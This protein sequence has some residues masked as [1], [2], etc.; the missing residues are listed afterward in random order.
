[1]SKYE[2]NLKELNAESF[3]INCYKGQIYTFPDKRKTY[4]GKNVPTGSN[5][6]AFI[7]RKEGTAWFQVNG[8]DLG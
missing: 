6:K 8:I 1:M 2:G 3:F 7:N 4:G 5:I